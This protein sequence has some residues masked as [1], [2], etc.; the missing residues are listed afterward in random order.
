[1]AAINLTETEIELL[2]KSINHC[3]ETCQEKDKDAPCTEC[4]ALKGILSKLA[5]S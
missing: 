2:K 1:M 3:L 5:A 4:E